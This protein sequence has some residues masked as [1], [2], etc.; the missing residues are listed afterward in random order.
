LVEFEKE[1]DMYLYRWTIEKVDG[2]PKLNNLE[3]VLS[4]VGWELEVRDTTDHSIHYL[5]TE[6]KL[7]TS[8]I[9]SENFIEYLELSNEQILQWVWDVVGKEA[10]ENKVRQ[11]LDDLRAPKEDQLTSFGMPWKGS[12][13][14]DGTGMPSPEPGAE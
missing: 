11:E 10:M 13:C 3:Q 9:D 6:T 12:C 8:A 2:F 14:P 7:D 4:V 5:R 1:I